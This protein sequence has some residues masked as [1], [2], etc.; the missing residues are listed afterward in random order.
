MRTL[1]EREQIEQEIQALSGCE[2]EPFR[3]LAALAL[4]ACSRSD[5]LEDGLIVAR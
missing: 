4:V 1:L 3:D 2:S 5:V